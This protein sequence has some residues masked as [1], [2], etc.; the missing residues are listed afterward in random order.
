MNAFVRT[1][2][3]AA[4]EI[5]RGSP[6]WLAEARRAAREDF[7]SRGL[8]GPRDE[9]WKYTNLRALESRVPRVGDPDAAARTVD[10]AAFAL[11]GCHGPRLV[12]V[13]GVLRPEHCR[14]E[15]LP[16]GVEF[17]PLG[18]L[19]AAGREDAREVFS[20]PHAEPGAALAR[21]NAALATDGVWLDVAAGV[22]L[23][24]PVHLVFIGADAG[25]DI[26]WNLRHGIRLGAGASAIV[27][28]QHLGAG[29]A[30]QIGNLVEQ[31]VLGEG[32]RLHHVRVQDAAVE[33]TLVSRTDITLAAGAVLDA[34]A[35]ELGAG[36]SRR[37]VRLRL[38]GE[39]ARADLRGAAV[40]RGRQH[41]DAQ[42][43][44]RHARPGATSEVRWRGI[45]DARARAV[46][47]GTI[48]VEEG[49]D[50]SDASLS[51]KNLLLS[52][53]A[54]IDT[55]PVLEIHADEVK[56]AHGATVGRLDER[57]L[58][59]LRS[60]GVPEA[61]ARSMLTFAFCSD[62]LDGIHFEPLRAELGERLAAHLPRMA[63]DAA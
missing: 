7:A 57:S 44:L 21:A 16:A 60:R 15:G 25:A 12:F 30:V 54:E 40:L 56:A 26:A 3:D 9:P 24:V 4:A 37:D 50:G 28:E 47:G 55:R 17:G 13:N 59:Y 49:A 27:V 42:F 48:V 1:L 39:G 32:A 19:L 29:G 11:P 22:E 46:F 45:A 20:L 63:G 2:L 41:M 23:E 43:E 38:D 35:L 18:G 36:L 51:N 8:P 33:A 31:V 34:V 58:F 6:R 53:H 62:V 61:I 14:L 52:P 10:P 5:E